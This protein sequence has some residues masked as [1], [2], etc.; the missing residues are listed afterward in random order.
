M[1][2]ALQNCIKVLLLLLSLAMFIPLIASTCEQYDARI[3]W[4][5]IQIILFTLSR[6]LFL[7]KKYW[8]VATL[9]II[10]FA[11]ICVLFMESY[12]M[13]LSD[14]ARCASNSC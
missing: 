13:V 8:W 5:F 9:E 7:E 14:V 11:I 4:V 12:N 10:G 2:H 3:E 1:K 6:G